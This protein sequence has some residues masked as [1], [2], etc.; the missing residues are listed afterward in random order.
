MATLINTSFLF[1]AAFARDVNHQ[2]AQDALRKLK[3]E[4]IVP[5]PVE[6]E[7]FYM[8]MTRVG[9]DRAVA[10]IRTLQSPAFTIVE[11]VS[12][13]RLRLIEIMQ[14]YRDARFD[15]TDVAIMALAERL[16]ITRT[17]T[18]DRRDFSIF[19]PRHCDY[20]ELLP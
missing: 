15:F 17:C 5:A 9:Y 16:D 2:I 3:T 14:Q 20:L 6:A 11:L 10:A 4:R 1:A 19:R 8:V 7:L 13:D 18:F 12:Q